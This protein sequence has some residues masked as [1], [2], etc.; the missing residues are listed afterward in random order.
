[1]K[2]ID[3]WLNLFNGKIK[4]LQV[5]HFFHDADNMYD[6]LVFKTFHIIHVIDFAKSC[7]VALST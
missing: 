4:S 3:I 7:M 6:S 2:T 1:M 5:I